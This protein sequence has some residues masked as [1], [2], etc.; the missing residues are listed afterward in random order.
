[1]HRG[2]VLGGRKQKARPLKQSH[3]ALSTSLSPG[4]LRN[5]EVANTSHDLEGNA[6]FKVYCLLYSVVFRSI[7][8]IVFYC[9]LITRN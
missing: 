1:M 9:S 8:I 4:L 2:T 3:D 6:I 5:S 7:V